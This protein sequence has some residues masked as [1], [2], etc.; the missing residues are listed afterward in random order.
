MGRYDDTN[1]G[2]NGR[3]F[4]PTHWSLI[5]AV[6]GSE[7]REHNA[8]LGQLIGLYWKPTYCWLRWHGYDDASAKDIVQEFFLDGLEKMK[9]EKADSNRGRFRTYIL[10]CLKNFVKNYERNKK[11]K[12]REPSRPFVSIDQNQ[13]D[14]MDLKLFHTKTPEDSFN[15]AWIRQLL[16]RVLKA[17][18][19][20]CIDTGKQQH[21]ELFR[22]RII[23]PI[24]ECIPQPPIKDLI[25]GIDLTQKQANNCVVTARR[26]FQRLLR[27]E[28]KM[29]ASTEEEID[30]EIKDLFRYVA[31]S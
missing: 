26:A 15:I 25:E 7:S 2:G 13:T 28:I 19:D 3:S 17:L 22:Q 24:L 16:M 31:E 14:G 21:Y 12:G 1:M 23:R 20:E 29:Y 10:T 9:F 4:P 5:D 30:L 11:A 18:E 8:A 6:Q 27:A